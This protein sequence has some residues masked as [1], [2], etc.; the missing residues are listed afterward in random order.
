MVSWKAMAEWN[1]EMQT[2]ME[3]IELKLKKIKMIFFTKHTYCLQNLNTKISIISDQGKIFVFTFLTL[4]N[5]F[6]FFGKLNKKAVFNY[7]EYC[8]LWILERILGVLMFFYLNNYFLSLFV[9]IFWYLFLKN[10]FFSKP[11]LLKTVKMS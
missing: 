5:F 6:F 10:Q 8:F 9:L 3:K 11:L 2:N 1:I 7:C 4:F